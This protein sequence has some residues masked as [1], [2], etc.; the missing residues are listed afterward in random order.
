M[1][2]VGGHYSHYCQSVTSHTPK[3]KPAMTGKGQR[4]ACARLKI[5]I[6]G[7]E[8]GFFKVLLPCQCANGALAR[9]GTGTCENIL[10]RNFAPWFPPPLNVK[11]RAN[12][13]IRPRP[14]L[15]SAPATEEEEGGGGAARRGGVFD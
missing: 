1:V 7:C 8:K 4:G 15:P 3:Q 13:L 6:V 11:Q 9:K 5:V 12:A 2:R 14:S 10:P